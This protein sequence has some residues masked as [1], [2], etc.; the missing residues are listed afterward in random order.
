MKKFYNYSRATHVNG[1]GRA[2][3]LLNCYQQIKEILDTG[4]YIIYTFFIF[5]PE[6]S[7]KKTI[8]VSNDLDPDQDRRSAGPDLGT[9]CLQR[10]AA[11]NKN[12]C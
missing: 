4:K 6:N 8:R 1:A 11:D 10:L 9:N 7:F 3:K 2:I 12:C 5:F